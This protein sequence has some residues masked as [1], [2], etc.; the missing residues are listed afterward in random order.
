MPYHTSGSMSRSYGGGYG[1]IKISL[2]DFGELESGDTVQYI[3]GQTPLITDHGE[4]EVYKI[5]GELFLIDPQYTIDSSTPPPFQ[6]GDITIVNNSLETTIE[7]V[8]NI[9]MDGLNPI[10]E[11]NLDSPIVF[12]S[13]FVYKFG[14]LAGEP[15][16]GAY[17]KHQDGTLMIN[18]GEI[19]VIHDMVLRE[20]IVSRDEFDYG[21][22]G[23]TT[24]DTFEIDENV[25]KETFS[26]LVYTK[27][28]SELDND[29]ANNNTFFDMTQGGE[30]ASIDLNLNTLQ[31]T[32]RDGQITTGRS[33]DEQL[34]FFKKD[35]NTPENKKDLTDGKLSLV[36]NNISSSFV[37]NGVVDLSEFISDKI[38]VVS[39]LSPDEDVV[40]SDTISQYGL[41]NYMSAAQNMPENFKIKNINYKLR[42]RNEQVKIDVPFGDLLHIV[43]SVGTPNS[44]DYLRQWYYYEWVNVLNLSQLTTPSTG[45]RV[46]ATKAKEILDTNIFE[47]LPPQSTQQ[48]RV[49]NFFQEFNELI[50][51]EPGFQ[52]VDNDGVGESI[53]N[54]T[55]DVES[56]ISF[57][58]KRGAFITRLDSHT[59][60]NNGV[61][62]VGKTLETMRNR[63]NNYLGD[64]DNV[65][66]EVQDQRPIYEN[67]SS[68]FLK[69][70]KPNQAIVLRAPNNGEL[71][72]QKNNSYLNDGFTVTMWVRFVSKTSE[73]TLFNFGN[74]L[75]EDGSGIRLETRTNVDADGNYRRWIRLAVREQDGTLRDNHWGTPQRGRRTANQTSPIDFYDDTVIH[76]IYPQILTDS[77]DEWYFICATYNPNIEELNLHEQSSLRNSKQYWLN[78]RND[79]DELVANSGLGAKCKVE[80]I[81]KSELLTARG[82][83]VDSLQINVS[84]NIEE[85]ETQEE[86]IE[87]QQQTQQQTQQVRT[88]TLS[89]TLAMPTPDASIWAVQSVDDNNLIQQVE[90]GM[91][92]TLLQYGQTQNF[93]IE[94][95]GGNTVNLT[96]PVPGQSIGSTIEFFVEIELEYEQES[97][98]Q[99]PM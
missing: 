94:S 58:N 29:Y 15:Y 51:P 49:D 21:I 91:T 44:D 46:S 2:Q 87:T 28:F 48:T 54:E 60:D 45:Q 47:L 63:L 76:E 74:P 97:D 92:V 82:F 7:S 65:V 50:G 84:E 3:T 79:D 83:L 4:V 90:A 6:S 93:V 59:E 20:I 77:L 62:N 33:D 40:I 70:R 22:E 53:Q 26:D 39:E 19:N 96:E 17:H 34:V 66:Q 61:R 78:H 73:G 68:G 98:E 11:I 14:D 41:E 69:I 35:R 55:E 36:I 1:T 10:V 31:T 85:Q 95:I 64:V 37:D 8:E 57:E 23:S 9:N 71:E 89:G 99:A 52:D 81:S 42:Y 72:F 75:E 86:E 30:E 88:V 16:Y 25:I 27:W 24:S 18:A 38:S 43:N 32:I 56:R 5:N 13:Q 12:P 80:I 67:K